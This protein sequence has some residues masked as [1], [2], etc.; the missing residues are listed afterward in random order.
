MNESHSG[1]VYPPLWR[2]TPWCQSENNRSPYSHRSVLVS[3]ES[4]FAQMLASS[5]PRVAETTKNYRSVRNMCVVQRPVI[6]IW[7]LNG[8]QR[9]PI[10]WGQRHVCFT[11]NI[12]PAPL[13][14]FSPITPVPLLSS[15]WTLILYMQLVWHDLI[16]YQNDKLVFKLKQIFGSWYL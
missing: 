13:A 6:Y 1:E 16:R 11:D 10:Q 8:H 14:S 4:L 5:C 2:L 9:R 12:Q 3:Q 15:R 7:R